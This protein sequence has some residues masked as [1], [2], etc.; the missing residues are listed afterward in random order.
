MFR[1]VLFRS[2]GKTT[3]TNKTKPATKGTTSTIDRSQEPTFQTKLPA[4]TYPLRVGEAADAD[5]GKK[6]TIY[7]VN[8]K[9]L[10]QEGALK[11]ERYR[12]DISKFLT[13]LQGLVNREKPTLY[14]MATKNDYTE[15]L[16]VYMRQKDSLLYGY[17]RKNINTLDELVTTF[18]KEIT[19]AGIIAWDEMVPATVNTATIACGVD[20]YIPVRYSAEKSSLYHLLTNT[21]GVS[22]KVDLHN[23]FTGKGTVWGTNR[24]STG[25][26]KNDAYVWAIEKYM[27]KTS[28]KYMGYAMDAA[29]WNGNNADPTYKSDIYATCV[30]N[31]DYFVA[32]KA[33]VFDLY[34]FQDDIATDEP[35]TPA[36]TDY[37]TLIE[38]L[39]KQY[40]KHQGKDFTQVTGFPPIETKYTSTFGGKY[41]AVM[42]EFET[43]QV[44]TAYNCTV[45]ADCPGM[46]SM[47]NGSVYMHF[48]LKS[49]YKNNKPASIPKYDKN[50]KYIMFYMG[51]ADSS[52][53][54]T[55]F[56]T[57][58]WQDES[59]GDIP[60][61]DRK[62]VV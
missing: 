54:I 48:P 28:S 23:K 10:C 40:K 21:Y 12:Y 55:R 49:S 13:A 11:G 34:M 35:K 58:T 38:I 24:A 36:G 5:S 29:S 56:Y 19:K 53:W 16:Y 27:S 52:S 8:Y 33:F 37:K 42:A 41:D 25:S 6:G 44:F 62:S 18:K 26:P 7:V 30:P 47:F 3:P 4:L 39:S 20:G 57:H 32:R 22:V 31:T 15:F 1:R 9:A 61:A 17:K 45:D 60:L 46:S 14:I 51:D 43:V 2:G 50:K 59:R